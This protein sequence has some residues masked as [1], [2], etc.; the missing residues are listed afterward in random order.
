M[1]QDFDRAELL[2]VRDHLFG[3]RT[4][5]ER[6]AEGLRELAEALG[7]EAETDEEELA[8][9]DATRRGED[10]DAPSFEEMHETLEGER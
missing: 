7:A 6:Q 10:P 3:Q 4:Q 9:M 2:E 5:R 8:E 1:T